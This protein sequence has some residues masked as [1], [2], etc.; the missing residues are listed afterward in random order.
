M[1]VLGKMVVF[2]QKLLFSGKSGCTRA[3]WWWLGKVVAFG[4]KLLY[5]GKKGCTREKMV[6]FEQKCL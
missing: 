3:N 2:V 4:Q 5:L 1:V 6:V